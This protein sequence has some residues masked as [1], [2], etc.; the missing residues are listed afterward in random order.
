MTN[1]IASLNSY[2]SPELGM[3]Y[4]TMMEQVAAAVVHPWE[5]ISELVRHRLS[6][7]QKELGVGIIGCGDGQR[8]AAL[9]KNL[10]G[11]SSKM[12]SLY[13]LDINPELL[14]I[15]GQ[16][17]EE[18]LTGHTLT[19]YPS[20]GDFTAREMFQKIRKYDPPMILTMLGF[21]LCNLRESEGAFLQTTGDLPRG[22]ILVV[23]MQ[24]TATDDMTEE[25]IKRADSFFSRKEFSK[26]HA[27]W[28]T[29]SLEELGYSGP[30][31]FSGEL[32]ILSGVKVGI[33]GG[34][35]IEVIA[36]SENHKPLNIFS[37]RRFDPAKVV[38]S[39]ARYG[40][41]SVG[42]LPFLEKNDRAGATVLLF[43]KT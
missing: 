11:D 43:E 2:R 30:F 37:F 28:Y 17:L 25:A 38:E 21:T 41:R 9:L 23:D 33:R 27:D 29:R 14:T 15:T 19:F 24:T 1:L 8:E 10:L 42:A 31:K 20:Q 5:K 4:L 12:I 18:R 3:L 22:T 35:R 16:T 39:F 7:S 32:T 13:G 40:W 34:Y 36:R 6:L 26:L